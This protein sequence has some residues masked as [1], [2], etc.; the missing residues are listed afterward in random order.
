MGPH[1]EATEHLTR[2]ELDA[3]SKF[4]GERAGTR[5]IYHGARFWL[6]AVAI[7]LVVVVGLIIF[8]PR[9]TPC[10]VQIIHIGGTPNAN[11]QRCAPPGQHGGFFNRTP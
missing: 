11:Y 8:Y 4:E 10:R 6:G 9:T 7:I 3:E 2:A 5:R 1:E